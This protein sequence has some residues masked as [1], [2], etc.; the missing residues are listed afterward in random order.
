MS[1]TVSGKLFNV[2]L[3]HNNHKVGETLL[4]VQLETE[5]GSKAKFMCGTSPPPEDLA[6]AIFSDQCKFTTNNTT[7]GNNNQ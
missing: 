1:I 7:H 3:T 2:I 5:T 6:D 4:M